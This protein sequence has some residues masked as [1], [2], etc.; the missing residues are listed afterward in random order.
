LN[1]SPTRKR[2]AWIALAAVCFFWGTTYLGIRVALEGLSPQ[3]LVAVRFLIS[4]AAILLWA[5][6]RGWAFPRGQE[7]AWAIGTG[8]LTLG[9]GNYCLSLAETYIPSGLAALFITIGPF[10]MVGTEAL[11]PGGDSIRPR[12]FL[13]MLVGFAGAVWLI[14][15]EGF[16]AGLGGAT[17]KGFLILQISCL[18]W[19]LG[20]ILQKRR[21]S[22]AN[23]ILLGGI[24][25][26]SVG[27]TFSLI[28]A[29]D[30]TWHAHWEPRVLWA[31][32][33]LAAFGS[34]VAYSAY[35]VALEG[36]PVAVVSI[37]T[38]INPVVAVSLGWLLLGESFG[39]REIAA[40][41]VIFLGV[42]IVNRFSKKP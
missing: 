41:C 13:G 32:L 37:Y 40:M 35:L 6:F 22:G 23:P 20:S 18:G 1:L 28:C 24:Q 39:K 38:Y 15:P 27:L 31:V 5:W 2:S 36:L 3:I 30:P 9:V 16:A 25:Q 10:W 21:R 26:L 33:Y 14:G 4:G 19:S 11:I 17:L 34:I 7:L 8:Q 29:F 42:F 12:A